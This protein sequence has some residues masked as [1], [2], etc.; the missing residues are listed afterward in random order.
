[1]KFDVMN[2]GLIKGLKWLDEFWRSG[3]KAA[4]A[5]PSRPTTKRAARHRNAAIRAGVPPPGE[6][7]YSPRSAYRRS[8]SS[9]SV[10]AGSSGGRSAGALH[11]SLIPS[12][13]DALEIAL[14]VWT[15]PHRNFAGTVWRGLSISTML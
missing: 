8:R 14:P 5:A 9:F 11:M 6:R 15:I 3:K 7:A 13:I 10:M 12:L 2:S 4:Q 1:M